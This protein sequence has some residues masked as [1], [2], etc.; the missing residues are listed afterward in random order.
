VTFTRDNPTGPER[1]RRDLLALKDLPPAPPILAE[2]AAVLDSERTSARHVADILARDPAIA[3][4]ILRLANSAYF[5]LAQPVS[6]VRAA[7][8]VLGFD[9]IRN[10][11]IGVTTLDVLTRRVG[12]ILDPE[13]FWRHSFAVA[14][15][16][17]LVAGRAG[18]SSPGTAFCAG[19]LHDIGK[20]VLATLA[21]ERYAR[22][23][24]EPTGA[25][26]A[27]SLAERERAEFGADHARVGEWLGEM[28]RFPSEIRE[29]LGRHHDSAD[30]ARP[31]VWGAVI[32]IADRL[33]TVGGHPSPPIR[34]EP[35]GEETPAADPGPFAVLGA[36]PGLWG[37]L[38]ER[39]PEEIREVDGLVPS[40]TTGGP[41]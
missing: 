23:L 26:E 12:A 7:C 29:G 31:S 36:D 28:W 6:D 24:P 19:I 37:K 15:A 22:V 20:L 18:A 40:G 21:P 41:R 8:V 5:C 39:Y 25:A 38:L 9:M 2:L 1:L 3:A 13:A 11:A 16:A 33:A 34:F 30:A 32:Q 14:I 4:R 27:P 17:R 10:L 35:P